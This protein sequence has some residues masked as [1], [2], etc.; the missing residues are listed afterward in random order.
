MT[1]ISRLGQTDP[2]TGFVFPEQNFLQQRFC[3]C[4]VL[5]AGGSEVIQ[6]TGLSDEALVERAKKGDLD[7]FEMLVS[8]YERK[9]Y[10]IAYRLTGHHEDASDIAQDAFIRVY[11]RLGDFRGDSS[12]YTWLTRIVTNACKDE[13][14]RRK[15]Q[16]VTYLDQPVES[17]DGDM[18]RQ[19]ADEATDGPEQALER[20]EM[21]SSVQ[22]AIQSLDDHFRMVLVM[23]DIQGL[24]YNQIADA[25]GENLGTVK[26]R[27]NRARS[28]LKEALESME[29]LSPQ[30]VYRPRRRQ[31]VEL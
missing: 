25:L 30:F 15:R 7:A 26:S 9:V 21:Q 18:T 24:S 17:D 16:N 14:R 29:L 20:R 4:P 31:G 11:T 13:L 10:T 8:R 27:L 2:K 28:A 3:L 19:M 6:V 22:K 5:A 1:N 23:R 12:F